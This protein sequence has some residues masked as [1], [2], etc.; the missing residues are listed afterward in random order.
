MPSKTKSLLIVVS[1]ISLF[2]TSPAN[3]SGKAST[4][5]QSSSRNTTNSNA[6]PDNAK[7]NKAASGNSRAQTCN[8]TVRPSITSVT[9]STYSP[10]VGTVLNASVSATGNPVPTISYEWLRGSQVISGQVSSS[11][12]V[13]SD[14]IGNSIRVRVTASNSVDF[15]TVSSN[16]TEPV[17]NPGEAPSISGV[18]I[19]CNASPCYVGTNYPSSLFI[20]STITGSPSPTLSYQWYADSVLT[21]VVTNNYILSDSDNGKT[22]TGV[23]TA[24]NDL[25]S[26]SVFTN[27]LVPVQIQYSFFS[28]GTN[29]VSN[30]PSGVSFIICESG[31]TT[32]CITLDN[33]TSQYSVKLL[34]LSGLDKYLTATYYNTSTDFANFNFFLYLTARS[35]IAP[36]NTETT[37]IPDVLANPRVD[38][39]SSGQSYSSSRTFTN[40]NLIVIGVGANPSN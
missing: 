37:F 8:V 14:D 13:T 7:S 40:G 28:D 4:T 39:T 25:G 1:L 32:N 20:S 17:P 15:T 33:S 26:T 24:T 3:S 31:S 36:F 18:S 2:I 22:I 23:I 35:Q 9:L 30:I 29:V 11:Y 21:S 10:V 38:F 12:L 27:F 6:C 5:N 34:T 19:Q 16:A